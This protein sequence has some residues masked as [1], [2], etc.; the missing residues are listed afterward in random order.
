MN[1]QANVHLCWTGKAL[2]RYPSGVSEI[3]ITNMKDSSR[4]VRLQS[5]SCD[6]S[7]KLLQ[8]TGAPVDH[9]AKAVAKA[10]LPRRLSLTRHSSLGNAVVKAALQRSLSLRPSLF[11]PLTSRNTVVMSIC[12]GIVRSRSRCRHKRSRVR[13][14]TWQ[15]LGQG[16]QSNSMSY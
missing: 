9:F 6:G 10:V 2:P 1:P 15:T 12:F 11:T 8:N 5:W 16:T 7:C 13:R 14:S 4:S 3:G